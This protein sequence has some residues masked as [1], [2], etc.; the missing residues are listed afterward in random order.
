MSRIDR[1]DPEGLIPRHEARVCII[2][3]GAKK[4]DGKC[5]DCGRDY[6]AER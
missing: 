3:L 1:H 6:G 5:P 2:C 4:G